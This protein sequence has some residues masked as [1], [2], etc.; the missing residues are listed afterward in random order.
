MAAVD[1]IHLGWLLPRADEPGRDL[2]RRIRLLLTITLIVANLLGVLIILALGLLVVP[3]PEVE[4]EGAARA[5]NL[6]VAGAY[7]LVCMPLGTWWGLKRLRNARSWL[8]Q[9]RQPTERERK[10]VLRAPRRIVVIHI[11]IWTAAAIGFGALNATFSL[12]AGGRVA[13]LIV[14]GG[15]VT[16]AFVYLIAERQLRP[17]A[18]RA[19]AAGIGDRRLAP[20]ITTRTL[21]AWAIGSAVPAFA[22]VLTAISTL[23]ERDFGRDELALI[24]LVVGA[25]TMVVGALLVFLA[26]RA[27]A[28]PIVA[29][30]KAVRSVGEGD[31]EV[32][33]DVYDGSEIGQLQTGF[34]DMVEGLRERE[35]IRD[36]FG[37]QV[38][39]DV[40]HAALE[41]G[42][43]LGGESRTVAILFCDV[44]GSTAIAADR[45][46]HE[47]V[48]LLNSFFAVV[49][50]VV[51]EHGGWVNKFEGDAA[52]AVFGA[53]VGVDDPAGCALAAGRE[54]CRRLRD[55][56]DELEAA[57]GISYGP[58]VAGNVGEESRFEYTVIGDPVNE[59]ARLSELAK[60]RPG[61]LLASAA[62]VE[63]AGE[64]EAGRWE[65]GEEVELRGRSRPTTLATPGER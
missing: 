55:E 43:E 16:C 46:P 40:A 7:L 49:V 22:L 64:A 47:V 53:P 39:E 44:V 6:S 38:G 50:E 15:V 8:E 65:L 54:L 18:A 25:V 34:N 62:A 24:V 14:F 21:V 29:L 10:V 28:D 5:L 32:G 17:A 23:V 19:L 63:A 36:L 20:G 51:G 27:I 3:L 42:V 26:A 2:A 45:D 12:E 52:L 35:R 57:I 11:V 33:V 4:D 41:Q 1:R 59:A 13:S 61:M 60:S 31:Y 9:D 56:L 37:R 48:E 58:V 30:R